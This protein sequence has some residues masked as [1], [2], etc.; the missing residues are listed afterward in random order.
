ML[1]D[2]FRGGRLQDR[3]G[4]ITDQLYGAADQ[5]GVRRWQ[6]PAIDVDGLAPPRLVHDRAGARQRWL[7]PI[8]V[9]VAP[10]AGEVRDRCCAL[11]SLLCER[12]G[13]EEC[14]S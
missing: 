8:E 6:A 2:D 13:R 7:D 9:G 1:P 4:I 3:I 12:R 10:N 5:R 14:R 11:A